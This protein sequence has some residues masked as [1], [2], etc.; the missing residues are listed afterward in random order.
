MMKKRREFMSTHAHT[1]AHTDFSTMQ[2]KSKMSV[3]CFDQIY[4]S[5]KCTS[6]SDPPLQRPE[7][8]FPGDRS[9]HTGENKL[10]VCINTTK[11]RIPQQDLYSSNKSIILYRTLHKDC[12]HLFHFRMYIMFK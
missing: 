4:P 12:G 10:D 9:Q 5:S 2:L 6:S 1:L 8:S 7:D 3:E 11:R